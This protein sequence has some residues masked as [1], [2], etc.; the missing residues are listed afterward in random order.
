MKELIGKT[1]ISVNLDEN[2][3]KIT[4]VTDKGK[5]VYE[6]FGDC[7][8]YSWF[9]DI[10]GLGSLIGEKVLS[11]ENREE[12]TDDEQKE[13]ESKGSYDCLRLYGILIKTEKGTCDIEFRND[14]NGYYGG[15]CELVEDET[16]E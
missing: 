5:I 14:S 2:G 16:K 11:V 13:A 10:E 9:S 8:S 1:I 12:W 15:S 3:T 7:C 4:F 6:T